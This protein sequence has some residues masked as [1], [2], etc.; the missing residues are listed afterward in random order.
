MNI[1]LN[2]KLNNNFHLPDV[3]FSG[4][5]L[6]KFN[7]K[8]I[9]DSSVS[10]NVPVWFT[11]IT[12]EDIPL[13]S[14]ILPIWTKYTEYGKAII[15]T[16][17]D[18]QYVAGKPQ[19]GFRGDFEDEFFMI[20]KCNET[21]PTN[22]VK[23]VARIKSYSDELFI[24]Y[25]QSASK[26]PNVEKLKGAGELLIY[27]IVKRAKELNKDFVDL[28]SCADEWYAKLGFNVAEGNGYYIGETILPKENYSKLMKYIE[29]KYKISES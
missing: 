26:L 29:S 16:F 12:K 24:N 3:S 10:E 25:L 5:R 13:L 19:K 6:Y 1:S 18:G 11:K 8:K 22:R 15:K 27:G 14:E 28:F 17:I 2:P 21:N 9:S 7:L 20:E 23:A 4:Q